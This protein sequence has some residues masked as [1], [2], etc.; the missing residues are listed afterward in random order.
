MVT[1]ASALAVPFVPAA[2]D[3]TGDKSAMQILMGQG[4]Y[5]GSFS[6]RAQQALAT[7][8]WTGLGWRMPGVSFAGSSTANPT[9]LATTTKGVAG[10]GVLAGVGISIAG[11]FAN[12]MLASSAVKL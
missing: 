5:T 6:T 12:P 10:M 2:Y 3:S 8:L 1:A 4:S 7:C 11:K 9:G